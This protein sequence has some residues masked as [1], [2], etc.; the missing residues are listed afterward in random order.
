MR[1]IAEAMDRPTISDVARLAGV[2]KKTV[3]RVINNS[4]LLARETREKVERIIADTGFVPN[5]TARA[6][7][8]KRN[9]LVALV[10][11]DPLAPE[12]VE[13][14]A[15]MVAALRNS[16]LALCV[17]ALAGNHRSALRA[18]GD[19]LEYHRPS[20]IVL[21]PPLSGRDDLAGLAWEYG[22]RCARL[23]AAAKS[24]GAGR[25]TTPDREAA[26]GVVDRLVAAGH[27]RIAFVSGREDMRSAQLCEL[28][29]LDAMAAHGLDRGPSLIAQGDG[30][31]ES[32]LAATRLLLELSPRPSAIFACT[33]A[34][35]VGAI[36][37]AHA[38]DIAIPG[39]LS[40][41]GFGDRPVAAQIHPP[42]T[43]VRVPLL[44]MAHAAVTWMIDPGCEEPGDLVFPVEL[45]ERA[46]FAPL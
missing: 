22:C 1:G 3:S 6:L 7:A 11:D 17:H 40:V 5:P 25:L 41:I 43:T 15:G 10:H 16:E 36:H 8:L 33:D 37:A 45:V 35:A 42:L 12:L 30:S 2:S 19:F 13:V 34:M 14:Q 44:E 29:Y 32:G 38:Q 24:D 26:A 21:M 46:S 9:M 27:R 28:G 20:A 4:P 31:F 39:E 18:L 23:G